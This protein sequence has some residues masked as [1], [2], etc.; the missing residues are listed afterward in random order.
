[1]ATSLRREV[2]EESA[3]PRRRPD[4]STDQCP[5]SEGGSRGRSDTFCTGRLVQRIQAAWGGLRGVI[6]RLSAQGGGIRFCYSAYGR[7]PCGAVDLRSVSLDAR[8]E[9]RMTR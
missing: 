5:T 3:V 7:N 9:P 4:D 6:R 2:N 1:M 8:V